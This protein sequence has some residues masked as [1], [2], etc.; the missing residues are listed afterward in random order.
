M[1]RRAEAGESCLD[2]SMQ[3]DDETVGMLVIEAGIGS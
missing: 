2:R 3:T 1:S